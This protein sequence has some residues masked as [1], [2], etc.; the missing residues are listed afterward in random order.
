MP[1][2]KQ[3]ERIQKDET[4]SQRDKQ[5]FAAMCGCKE[6]QVTFVCLSQVQEMKD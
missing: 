6:V 4:N 3:R 2:S 1:G 5:T